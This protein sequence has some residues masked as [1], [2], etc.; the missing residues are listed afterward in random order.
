M[1]LD[2]EN[3]YKMMKKNLMEVQEKLKKD[4]ERNR[5]I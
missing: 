5:K 2:L 4:K 3:D 1:K